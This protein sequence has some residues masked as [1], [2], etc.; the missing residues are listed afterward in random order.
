MNKLITAITIFLVGA[1]GVIYLA[2]ISDKYVPV[3]EQEKV[4]DSKNSKAL[5]KKTF[6]TTATEAPVT[7]LV[8]ETNCTS[9]LDPNVLQLLEQNYSTRIAEVFSFNDQFE[10]SEVDHIVNLAG[11]DIAQ[12]RLAIHGFP[13]YEINELTDFNSEYKELSA[14]ESINL[15]KII[16]KRDYNELVS[17]LNNNESA[18]SSNIGGQML[19]LSI[20]KQDPN[21]APES[22][23]ILVEAGLPIGLK[24]LEYL[25]EEGA[26]T[27]QLVALKLAG[28][29]LPLT[30]WQKNKRATSLV[31]TAAENFNAQALEY[32]LSLGVSAEP[33]DY[34]NNAL[35]RLPKP[36]T[37]I[38]KKA[39]I[40]IFIQLIEVGIY[41]TSIYSFEKL[42]DWLPS[43]LKRRYVEQLDYHLANGVNDSLL[44]ESEI[45]KSE[46]KSLISDFNKTAGCSLPSDSPVNELVELNDSKSL[47]S[48]TTQVNDAINRLANAEQTLSDE[49]SVSGA[50]DEEA[51]KIKA[52][53]MMLMGESSS[54][55]ILL[56][57]DELDQEFG[58]NDHKN[59]ALII[60]LQKNAPYK[61]IKALLEKGA[62]LPVGAIQMLALNKNSDLANKLLSYGL[63]PEQNLAQMPSA[64]ATSVKL[65][66][67]KMLSFL[68]ANGVDVNQNAT[69]HD[70][71]LTTAIKQFAKGNGDTFF[72]QR[73]VEYGANY[74][75]SD[76]E[77]INQIK[78]LTPKRYLKLTEEVPNLS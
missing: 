76:K 52:F 53:T 62:A 23:S 28:S 26:T 19:S 33:E 21:I 32:W 69:G 48:K 14:N 49:L 45:L 70:S 30:L 54:E 20:L 55:E 72:I 9:E 74:S 31:V 15:A 37:D 63:R 17:I 44:V 1:L 42:D 40:D 27:E 71:A 75:A 25:T 3:T 22:I 41:P 16:T 35:D 34:Y 13:S 65:R 24:E 36:T 50:E 64:M 38:E 58:G 7:D 56:R 2:S 43:S 11:L 60:A 12:G 77:L 78:K 46:L 57:A 61:E 67:K 6:S 5:I 59:M 18:R 4:N 10:P 39:A 68:L 66:D 29:D 8:N 47:Q 73:L 51:E